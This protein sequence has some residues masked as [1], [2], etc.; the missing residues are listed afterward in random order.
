MS[1]PQTPFR[2]TRLR[3]TSRTVARAGEARA[4]MRAG[5]T[6]HLRHH[7]CRP[8]WS[9]S[10]GRAVTAAAAA[11]LIRHPH[12]VPADSALFPDLPGQT[13]RIVR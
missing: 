9:L 8:R 7:D 4:A 12:V 1:P 10:D 3:K 6:L 13:W 11:I 5:Q 2:A